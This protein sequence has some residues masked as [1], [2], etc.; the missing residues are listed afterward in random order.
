MPTPTAA[1]TAPISPME[2][3]KTGQLS[4]HWR[5]VTAWPT[6]PP[7]APATMMASR[8][9]KRAVVDGAAEGRP[10]GVVPLGDPETGVEAFTGPNA[11]C[12]P[13]GR[14]QTGSVSKSA[15]AERS[16]GGSIH[17]WRVAGGL[18]WDDEHRL[19][20]V[21]N[22]R[23]DGRVEWTPPGGV[24]DPAE[25][26]VGALGRELTEETG[27]FVDIWDGPCYRVAVDFPDRAMHL[28]VEVYEARSHSGTFRLEDPD[29]IVVD[30]RFV[31]VD[32]AAALLETAPP[33]VREPVGT[34]LGRSDSTLM[35][36][37]GP[38]RFAFVAR[39]VDPGSLVVKRVDPDG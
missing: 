29:R 19:L 23:R 27:L 10:P 14:C 31:D 4:V 39:G 21:A 28:S 30:A 15:A 1:S 22:R 18:L 9:R 2:P 20:L 34:R 35:P 6:R 8:A 7:Q 37:S 24:V 32:E 33:W 25:D 17:R 13:W 5:S 16:S 36:G 3:A 38:E 11:T 26:M 12:V